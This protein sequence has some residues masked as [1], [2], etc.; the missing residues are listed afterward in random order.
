M[1]IRDRGKIIEPVIQPLGYDWKIGI[2]I[3]SSFAA[4]EVF[5]GSLST[6][7]SVGSDEEALIKTRLKNEVNPKTGEPRYNLATCLSLLLFYAFALQCMSTMAIA[8]KETGSWRYPMLQ[9]IVMLVLA[10]VSA[11]IAYQIF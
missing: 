10:Y 6:I 9:F 3:I 4:R 1:C 8:K 2:A 5:V 11:F 7:Y